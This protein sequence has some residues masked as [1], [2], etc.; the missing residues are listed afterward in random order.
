MY[1]PHEEKLRKKEGE[2]M[3]KGINT[4]N[5]VFCG[6]V[7]SSDQELQEGTFFRGTGVLTESVIFI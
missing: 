3:R 4:L 2:G 6:I 7:E 5:C 1:S